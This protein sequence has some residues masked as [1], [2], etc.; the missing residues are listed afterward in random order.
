[1]GTE[2]QGRFEMLWDCPNCGTE[3][4][5]GVTHRHCPSC[6]SAQDPTKRYFPPDDEKVAVENH[7]YQ[8]ADKVCP[9]CE[10]PNAAKA[11]FCVN[12]GSPMDGAKGVR[13]RAEQAAKGNFQG[14]SAKNASQEHDAAKKSE[15]DAQLAAH[16][17]ASG[18]APPPTEE[19][20]SGGGWATKIFGLLA[21][22]GVLLCCAGI[23]V[24][25][26]WKK[27]AAITVTG[28]SWER[29]VAVESYGPVTKSD[30]KD[31]VPA[32][33]TIV[34]CSPE[35]KSTKKVEDGQECVNKRVDKGDGSFEQVKDCQT[36][37]KEEPVY[38]DK[39]SYTVNTWSKVRD[40]KAAGQ[41]MKPEPSWPVTGVIY[42]GDC[43]GCQREGSKTETYTVSF[44]DAEGTAH[45][46]TFPQNQ[47][48]SM[49]DGSAWAAKV[50][51]I[52]GGL[53]CASLT[54]K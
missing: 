18:H 10:T 36:K 40:A 11:E 27:D 14:D 52:G 15:R 37:Y 49:A 53:D 26:L 50:G 43:L 31:S 46:C 48:S 28:H 2:S 29:V 17:R 35:K 4:L 5:L 13:T 30:W 3:K 1:M 9:A 39:C 38:A 7:P 47:W 25:A 8:G 41:G 22:G 19:K 33:A 12:C 23:L 51:V 21:V 16:A 34:S 42:T 6:G 24:T 44:K 54:K 32:N 20:K 45:T